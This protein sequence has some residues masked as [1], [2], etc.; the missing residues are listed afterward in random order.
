MSNSLGQYYTQDSISKLLVSKILTKN[1]KSIL[2]LGVGDG[3]LVRVARRKWKN[4]KIIGGD[5][6]PNNIKVLKTE[7][8]SLSLFLINGLSSKLNVDLKIKLGTIDVG[9]CNPPYLKITRNKGIADIIKKSNLGDI[10][11]Y[12]TVTS[13]LIFLAQN[14]RLIREGGELGIILPDGLITSHN[15]E[16]FRKQIIKNYDVRGVIELPDKVFKKTEAKTYILVIKKSISKNQYLKIYKSNDKG[17]ITDS[18]QVSKKELE[19]RMDFTYNKWKITNKTTGTI[20]KDLTTDIF[21]GNLS[22][23]ELESS[24]INFIHTTD[25]ESNI[26]F[27]KYKPN[28]RLIKKYKCAQEGDIVF[29]RVGKR[30]LGRVLIIE[31]GAIVIT[32]CLYVI[33]PKEGQ[34]DFILSTLTSQYGKDWVNAHSHG[35]CAKVISKTDLLNLKIG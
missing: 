24:N 1:P 12:K 23:K 33:R 5:I 6:D 17:I 18:I 29:S 7:F 2:E 20:L 11:H 15:F 3:S 28:K 9:I 10:K 25:L 31:K 4:S 30:C 27:K 21:R 8:P 16:I 22:K 13:D 14:L 26:T 34:K 19:F 35:V 32:D